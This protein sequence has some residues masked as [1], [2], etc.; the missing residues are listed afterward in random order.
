MALVDANPAKVGR[1]IGGI[2]VEHV[3]HLE[4][5]VAERHIAVGIIATP[6]AAAQEVADRLVVAGC[7]PS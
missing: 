4:P 7:A 2:V 1:D 3:D 5:I 6:A